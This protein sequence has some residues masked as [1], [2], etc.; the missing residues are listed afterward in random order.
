[1][2]RTTSKPLLIFFLLSVFISLSII[3]IHPAV[4]EGPF[5]RKGEAEQ[6]EE[7]VTKKRGEMVMAL[8]SDQA[9]RMEVI[10]LLAESC[11]LL[12]NS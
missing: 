5:I 4:R 11:T 2:L 6:K 12:N 1:M 9:A 7:T 3:F 8:G 10:P